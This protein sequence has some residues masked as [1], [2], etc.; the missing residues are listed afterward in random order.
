MR[1]LDQKI[2]LQL[3]KDSEQPVTKIAKKVGA[4]RQT[5]AKKIEQFKAEGVIASLTARLNPE[6]F[7]LGTK[8]YILLHEDPRGKLRRRNEAAIKQFHQVTEFYRLFG[9]YSAVLE[10]LVRDSKE[11]TKLVKRIHGLKGVRETET[12]IVHSTVKDEP[13][14][15]YVKILKSKS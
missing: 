15:P 3:I 4:S 1:E 5:V 12:F 6:K 9:R 7:G 10:V 14:A 2:L 8:A 13:E 11:L